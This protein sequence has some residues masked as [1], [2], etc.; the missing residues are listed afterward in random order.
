MISE[1]EVELES[2]FKLATSFMDEC[3]DE[4]D[5]DNDDGHV[6]TRQS[7]YACGKNMVKA[8]NERVSKFSYENAALKEK[9]SALKAELGNCKKDIKASLPKAN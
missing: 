7:P 9:V 8:A 5:E 2:H 6:S 3:L 4:E 1:Q